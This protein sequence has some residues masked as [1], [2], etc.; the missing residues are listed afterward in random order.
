MSESKKYGRLEFIE[1]TGRDKHRN[2]LWK[3][4]CECGKEVILRSYTVKSGRQKSCGCLRK[5][6]LEELKNRNY[7]GYIDEKSS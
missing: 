5:Q 6:R 2:I 4:R 7:R 1:E 3:M